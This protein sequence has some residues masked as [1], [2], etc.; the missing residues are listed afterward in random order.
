MKIVLCSQQFHPG[1]RR[2][3]LLGAISS[4]QY[5][6]VNIRGTAGTRLTVFWMSWERGEKSS[7]I[8]Q[9]MLHTMITMTRTAGAV[10]FKAWLSIIWGGF[11][12]T[13]LL[14]QCLGWWGVI[15]TAC[16]SFYIHWSKDLMKKLASF[17]TWNIK[18]MRIVPRMECPGPISQVPG[19]EKRRKD[20]VNCDNIASSWHCYD[21]SCSSWFPQH[22]Q[23][24]LLQSH[25]CQQQSWLY[26]EQP[27]HTA[28]PATK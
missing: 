12:I 5:Y 13:Q 15:R 16:C 26:P 18:Q 10:A 14:V 21:C 7:E 4:K 11:I 24:P 8:R 22:K 3:T 2:Q 17:T 9:I 19:E 6:I 23:D 28:T 20:C 1:N 27:S 25:Y